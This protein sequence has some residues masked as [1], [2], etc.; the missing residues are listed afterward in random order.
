LAAPPAAAKGIYAQQGAKKPARVSEVAWRSVLQRR[1]QEELRQ[2][3]LRAY[4]GRCAITNT[5]GE[6][7]LEVALIDPADGAGAQEASNALL[8]RGD[9]RTLFE[10]NLVRVHPRTRKVFV[11]DELKRSNYGRLRARRLR[12]PEK[13]EERPSL[14]ALQRRWEAGGGDRGV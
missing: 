1:G 6:P 7:A 14:E 11:A 12:L 3:L 13:E 4:D 5:S 10:L 2:K 8:L 9:V